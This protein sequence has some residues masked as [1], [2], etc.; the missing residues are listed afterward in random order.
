[1][2]P[3]SFLMRCASNE[4]SNDQTTKKTSNSSKHSTVHQ[5]FLR[6]SS[7]KNMKPV[8]VNS[9]R[10]ICSITLEVN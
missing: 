8:A 6:E 2:T 3:I 7:V 1:M 5:K 10:K 4:K 9:N